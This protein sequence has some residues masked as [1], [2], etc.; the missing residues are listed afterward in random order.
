VAE[1]AARADVHRVTLLRWLTRGVRGVRLAGTKAGAAWRVR[2]ADLD[3]FL[4]E[5]TRLAL[6]GTPAPLVVA[7]QTPAAQ[8]ERARAAREEL[9]R[10]GA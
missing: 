10:L 9:R 1:A 6:E 5:L 4:G 3:A 7:G 8:R 2:A